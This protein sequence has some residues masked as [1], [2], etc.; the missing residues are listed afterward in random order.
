MNLMA[1]LVGS[2]LVSLGIIFGILWIAKMI[3]QG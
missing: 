3:W 2:V 1:L